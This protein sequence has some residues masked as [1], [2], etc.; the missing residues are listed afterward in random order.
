MQNSKCKI[1]RRLGQKL[2]L[3]GD[4]CLS[5]KCPMI[6][7]PYPPGMKAKKRRR[8]VISEYGKELREKQKLKAWY[9]LKEKQFRK[10]IKE[11]LEKRG[12]VED[13]NALLVK[14]LE[15]RLD[16]VI[17]RMGFTSSRSQAHQIISHN[18]FLVNGK[19]V[20]IPSFQTKK[21]DKIS[22]NPRSGKK[23]IFQNLPTVLKKYKPP[24]WIKVNVEKLEGQITGT[25]SLEET[26]P[27]AEISAIF[28]YYSR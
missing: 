7:K 9:N 19:M 5:P 28:E 15:S 11:V 3:K 6:T 2:F 26:A 10:Y 20:N 1:C 4:R 27:P 18:H 22:L 25:P 12:K 14:K 23:I 21:G 8:R 16:N 17:F 13:T 24:S